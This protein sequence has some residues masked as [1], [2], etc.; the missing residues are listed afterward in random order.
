[1]KPA[2]EAPLFEALTTPHQSGTPAGL[3]V[4]A[5]VV[6]AGSAVLA[7]LFWSLGA[8]PVAG[9]M[10]AEVVLVLFLLSAHRRWLRQIGER[11]TLANGRVSVERTDRKARRQRVEFDAYWAQVSLLPRHGRASELRVAARGR[12]TEVGSFLSEPEKADLADALTRALRN[13]RNPI[14]D[15]P[16]LRG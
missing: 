4:I 13:Y 15:N 11:I 1:M 2:Q 5:G 10:G 6:V 16:Q 3:R 12:S 8:W 7:V 9:F 14:F